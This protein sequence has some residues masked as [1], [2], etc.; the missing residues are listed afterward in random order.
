MCGASGEVTTVRADMAR[1]LT[2]VDP[3]ARD[4]VVRSMKPGAACHRQTRRSAPDR[5]AKIAA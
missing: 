5:D 2:G 1:C 3:V 4:P